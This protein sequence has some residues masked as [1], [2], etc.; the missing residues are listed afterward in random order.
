MEYGDFQTPTSLAAQMAAAVKA[1]EF[2]PAAI[3]EPTCGEGT[4]LLAALHQFPDVKRLVGMDIDP[5]HLDELR[6]RLAREPSLPTV[7]VRQ[8]DFF[9]F[10]WEAAFHTLPDPLL[11]IGNPP[12]VTAAAL[13]AIQSSNLPTKSNFH[14]RR[15]LDAVMG[16]SNFDIAEWIILHLMEC[17]RARDAAV[18]ML[19]KTSVARRI[20]T[21]MWDHRLPVTECRL[22]SFDATVHFGVSASACLLLCRFGA[23]ARY[24]DQCGVYDLSA[25]THLKHRLG[26][27]QG[28]IIADCEAFLRTQHLLQRAD[29]G[30]A[31]RW[32]SGIKH[33]C[34]PVMELTRRNG[35]LTNGIGEVV[36]VEESHLYPMSKG[37]SVANGRRSDDRFMVV[38]QQRPGDA[39][40]SLRVV[41]PRTWGYLCR[42]GD[43]LDRRRSSIYR[44]RPRFSVF[45][46]GAYTFAP[47]KVAVS[48]LYKRLRF[49]AVGP[50]N[51]SP[52]VFDDT[53]YF[54]PC[55]CAEEASLLSSLLNSDL[56]H[57]FLGAF[58]FWDAKRPVTVDVL[59]KLDILALAEDLHAGE[60]LAALRSDR[61][62]PRQM[63][64]FCGPSGT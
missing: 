30:P 41:A 57:D 35:T 4:V 3:V 13:G 44:G 39:T 20:L 62:V 22:F 63:N 61:N 45:G 1:A 55:D 12:W 19:L 38:P 5:L 15:G 26:Y 40:D 14:G 36:D 10:D 43:R 6:Q 2:A 29:A 50:R 34:A 46:V 37:S 32:R 11:V 33:D 48:G 21:Y 28:Q 24:S 17:L 25:P 42:H 23:S 31:Y 51:G 60:E 8:A 54:L 49:W 9:D 53:V 27:Y 47:W 64:L 16:K 18:A 56:S 58:V 52:V 7:E 59:Q